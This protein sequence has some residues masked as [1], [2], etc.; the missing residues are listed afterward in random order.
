MLE[1][2]STIALFPRLDTQGL[3]EMVAFFELI[4]KTYLARAKKKAGLA[5]AGLSL[6]IPS[7]PASDVNATPVETAATN[8]VF[9]EDLPLSGG[10]PLP[11][12]APIVKS[13]EVTTGVPPDPT[14]FVSQNADVAVVCGRKVC[15]LLRTTLKEISLTLV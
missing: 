8:D 13:L 11:E 10:R 6:L 9:D 7:L 12:T 5:E 14:S 4:C 3:P 1:E 2:R 15:L